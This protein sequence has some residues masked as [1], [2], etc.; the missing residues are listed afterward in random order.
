MQVTTVGTPF[1]QGLNRLHLDGA[2]WIG[3]LKPSFVGRPGA[4]YF[5]EARG[6]GITM[7]HNFMEV[8]KGNE[9][10]MAPSV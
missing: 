4:V 5:P 9:W 8:T 10:T 7:F 2:M 6:W 1:F 3:F